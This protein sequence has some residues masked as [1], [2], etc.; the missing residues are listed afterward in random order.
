MHEVVK[1]LLKKK[2]IPRFG[3]LMS[4]LSDNKGAFIARLSQEVSGALSLLWKL[5]AS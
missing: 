4:I 3:L 2:K 1:A 5:H